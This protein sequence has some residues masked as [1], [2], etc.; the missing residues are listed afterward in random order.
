M[1]EIKQDGVYRVKGAPAGEGQFRFRKGHVVPDEV[2]Y[3]RV[4]D[5]PEPTTDAVAER[6]AKA[7]AEAAN[8][9]A[10]KPSDKSA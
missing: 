7:A 9:A 1:A 4:G 8:K 6:N 2:E 5:F 3:E 10:P